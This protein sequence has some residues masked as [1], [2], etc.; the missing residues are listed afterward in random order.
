MNFLGL[1]PGEL[2]LIA[3]LGL[4]IFGPG[5]LPEIAAQ[6]GRAVRDF[7]RSTTEI[8]SEFQRSFQLEDPPIPPVPAGPAAPFAQSATPEVAEQAAP[9]AA[10][11]EPPLADTSEWHWESAETDQEPVA[12][13]PADGAAGDSFWQW[14]SPD[15]TA[16]LPTPTPAQ[17]S[18][19]TE[20]VVAVEPVDRAAVNRKTRGRRARRQPADDAP[21]AGR[22]GTRDS[23]E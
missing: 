21:E 17:P 23:G 8:T 14:D 4:I 6:V 13:R 10:R 7:R 1:G 16:E 15:Q 3:A 5:R 20:A 2:I 19:N 9:I 18:S 11:P 22:P 12:T